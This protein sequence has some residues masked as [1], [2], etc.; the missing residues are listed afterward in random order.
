MAIV[1]CSRK[2]APKESVINVKTMQVTSATD[3]VTKNYVG[4][5]AKRLGT[6][7]AQE[8]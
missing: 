6:Y 3:G 7:G 1:G 5:P 4:T 8:R 2:V